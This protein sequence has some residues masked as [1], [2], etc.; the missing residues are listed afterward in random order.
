MWLFRRP[1][2]MA[3]GWPAGAALLLWAAA[4]GTLTLWWLHLPGAP[5]APTTQTSLSPTGPVRPAPGA[6]ERALGHTSATPAT[7]APEV[8]KRFQLLGVIAS[9]S[10]QGSALLR[11]DDQPARAFVAGQEVSEGWRLQSVSRETAVL[12]NAA[13][14]LTLTLPGAP[15]D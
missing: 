9:P 1:P 6:M 3:A 14:A 10:G 11:I 12:H 4:A 8:Q 7:A 15:K 5:S 13:S 2:P